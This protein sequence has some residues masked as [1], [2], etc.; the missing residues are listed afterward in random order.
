MTVRK[1]G[2]CRIVRELGRGGMGVVYEA[3]QEGLDRRV[4]VK[5]LDV[6]LARSRELTERFRREGRAYSQL[7]HQA[8]VAVHDL[9]EKEDTLYLITDFVD[10]IDLNR[11]LLQGGPFPPSCV[12]VIGARLAEALDYV[13]F[14]GLLHRDVKPA[15]VMISRDGEVKLMDFGIAKDQNA[16]DLTRAGMLV[17]SPSYIAPE[18]LGGEP[19]DPQTDV[20]ALG[21]TLYEL[22]TG[23]KP[24]R[25]ADSESLFNAIRNGDFPPLRRMAPA[26]PR[27]LARAVE[28]CLERRRRR[29]RTAG[30][31]A[32]ELEGCVRRSLGGTHPQARLV[33]FMAHRGFADE[34]EALTHVD[35]ATLAATRSTDE[36]GSSVLLVPRKPRVRWSVALVLAAAAGIAAWLVRL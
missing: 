20:W 31:L 10:G 21:V 4:A 26:V 36:A 23:E 22:L 2:T 17:G 28:R 8:V 16:S 7:R 12:A 9:L 6:K 25:G 15:N 29:W 11:A 35:P 19:A 34:K 32:T 24:F 33:A 30:A 3:F 27:R 14:N 13:H 5:A 18:L 1:V